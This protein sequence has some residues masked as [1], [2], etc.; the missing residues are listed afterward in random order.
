MVV[1]DEITTAAVLMH[2]EIDYE[3]SAL[4]VLPKRIAISTFGKSGDKKTPYVLRPVIRQSFTYEGFKRFEVT[5]A[6]EIE[7]PKLK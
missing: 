7:D 2:E 3:R 4:G 1:D 6:T 5:T